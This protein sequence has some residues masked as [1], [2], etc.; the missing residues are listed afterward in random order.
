[1]VV[2]FYIPT[3]SVQMFQFPHILA[4]TCYIVLFGVF[5]V[6]LFDLFLIIAILTDVKW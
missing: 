4:N 1:M 5:Y 3:N 2:Q 6:C